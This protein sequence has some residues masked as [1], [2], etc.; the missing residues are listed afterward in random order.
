ML[1]RTSSLNILYLKNKTRILC[2]KYFTW[3]LVSTFLGT[4]LKA[5]GFENPQLII[6]VI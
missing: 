4:W 5:L 1:E 6:S 3:I 2:L